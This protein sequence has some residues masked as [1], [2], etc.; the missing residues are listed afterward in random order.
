MFKAK[1]LIGILVT[2]VMVL[3]MGITTLAAGSP[4][5]SGVVQGVA[6]DTEWQGNVRL[7]MRP[8]G[9]YD[10]MMAMLD[11]GTLR[12]KLGAEYVEGMQVVDIQEL[13]IEEGSE[14]DLTSPFTVTFLVPG[15][16]P[17]TNVAILCYVDGEW[18]VVEGVTAGDG[19]ITVTLNSLGKIAFVIDKNTLSSGSGEVT[20]VQSIT[21]ATSPKTGESSAVVG[22]G[23]V[24]LLAAGGA[25]S[26]S[27]KKRA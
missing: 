10:A 2:G 12:A 13:V 11:D 16:T 3:A 23:L 25:F 17:G 5:S 21:S 19:T 24:A 22:L 26:L 27:R 1:K 15:V 18:T 6:G 20:G 4:V 9:D 7:G 8:V 14:S